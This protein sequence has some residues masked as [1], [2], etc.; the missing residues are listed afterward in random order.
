MSDRERGGGASV[1]VREEPTRKSG[2]LPDR[3]LPEIS[4]SADEGEHGKT[5]RF[6][7]G[8]DDALTAAQQE[9]EAAK[10]RARVA[11]A[12]TAEAE[13]RAARATSSATRTAV[14]ERIAGVDAALSAAKTA[15]EGARAKLAAAIE[16]GDSAAIADAQEEI[17]TQ[18]ARIENLTGQ[19]NFLDNEK[20]RVEA[21]PAGGGQPKYPPGDLAWIDRHPLFK[22]DPEYSAE[23]KAAAYAA[24]ERG[25]QRGSPAYYEFIDKRM[26][27]MYGE[28]HGQPG[29]HGQTPARGDRTD[30]EPQRRERGNAAS[31]GMPR[32]MGDESE[33]GSSS[34]LSMETDYGPVRGTYDANGKLKISMPSEIMRDWTEAAGWANMSLP[35]YAAEQLKISQEVK[36]GKNP[37]LIY[38]GTRTYR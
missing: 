29:K 27:A 18:A 34:G 22:T 7:K 14:D 24:T 5:T 19:K 8:V 16:A 35:E 9:T 28:G 33:G 17:G 21:Q 12:R 11:E 6:R 13:E 3:E 10:E 36:Q 1:E 30:P 23:V 32:T 2:D 15:K 37:G 25:M 38:E 26:L 20:K 31:M 4:V